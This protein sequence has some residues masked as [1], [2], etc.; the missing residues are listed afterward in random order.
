MIYVSK[1]KVHGWMDRLI[2]FFQKDLS[3]KGM[4]MG[5]RDKIMFSS[6]QNYL[7]HY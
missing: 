7:L 4:L 2:D 5:S 3:K 1:T 6:E